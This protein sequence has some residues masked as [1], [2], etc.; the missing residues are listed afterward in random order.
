MSLTQKLPSDQDLVGI[1]AT[2]FASRPKKDIYKFIGTYSMASKRGAAPEVESLNLE[3]T[4]W[5]NTVLATGNAIGVVIY[6]GADT[7]SVM[8]TSSPASKVGLLDLELNRLAKV[9]FYL[10]F[11]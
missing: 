9:P 8:N 6:T 1:R 4:L 7:R 10:I 2:L 3:N 5:M 11:F